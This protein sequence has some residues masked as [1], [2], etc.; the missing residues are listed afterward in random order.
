VLTS[1]MLRQRATRTSSSASARRTSVQ[2]AR[3]LP[4]AEVGARWQARLDS[5]QGAAS[6]CPRPLMS[7]TAAEQSA[8]ADPSAP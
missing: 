8:R 6:G 2:R 7:A 5:R 1:R 4:Q 3:G